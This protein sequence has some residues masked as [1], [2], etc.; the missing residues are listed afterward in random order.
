MSGA[1]AALEAELA[2]WTTA[3]Q[4]P[5]FW[6]RDDDAAAP[7]AALNRLLVLAEQTGVPVAL[8]VIPMRAGPALADMLARH[9]GRSIV[10]QHGY[11]HTNHAGPDRKK[12]EFTA[13]RPPDQ[14][15]SEIAEGQA[16][17]RTLFGDRLQAIFVPPWNRFPDMM[18]DR[19]PALGL[20]GISTYGPRQA[21]EAAP[22]LVRFN[23]HV[24]PIDWK[25][26]RKYLG[27][28]AFFGAVTAHLAAR[29]AG[30]VDT[31]EPTGILSHHEVFD[32]E[33]FE[34]LGYLLALLARHG[35]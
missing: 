9:R 8:A 34:T 6:W 17:L 14:M 32:E 20:T 23:T 26:E 25:N 18:L 11:A 24:D 3:G 15:A 16:K 1:L 13:E 22:G 27:D 35:R 33:A 7:S 10:L 4:R 5:T 12:A 29:R 19:L 30:T 21:R 31:E 28:E 2:A